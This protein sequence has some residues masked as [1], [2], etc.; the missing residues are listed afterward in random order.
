MKYEVIIKKSAKKEIKQLPKHTI[1]RVISKIK[2]LEEDAYPTGSIKIVG[3]VNTWR[4]RAGNYRIIYD[5][6]EDR[7]VIEVI[8]VRH[9]KDAYK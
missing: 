6:Y 7:V 8:A 9:R 3:S 4:L 1:S 2:L 5:V